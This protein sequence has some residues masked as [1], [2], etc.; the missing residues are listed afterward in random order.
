MRSFSGVHP[1]PLA[2]WRLRHYSADACVQRLGTLEGIKAGAISRWESVVEVCYKSGDVRYSTM[3]YGS[4][5]QGMQ[6]SGGR[7]LFNIEHMI[8]YKMY[9]VRWVLH[10]RLSYLQI[11]K[12][13]YIK[14]FKT[15]THTYSHSL[16]N[17]YISMAKH[18]HLYVRTNTCIS[19]WKTST[20]GIILS[21]SF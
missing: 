2:L 9:S 5:H 17:E 7:N 16:T 6:A 10:Y 18:I 13:V 12:H 21:M 4:G 8:L 15:Q 11:F 14:A 19:I 1:L 3:T 20:Q